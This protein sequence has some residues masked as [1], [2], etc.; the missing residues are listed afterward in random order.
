MNQ[1]LKWGI[2]NSDGT[3]D[4]STVSSDANAAPPSG[5]GLNAEA[6][7]ALLGGPSD[8]DLMKES[9]AA[10]RSPDI[11]L[12]N[13]LVAFDNLEQLVETIDNANNMEPLGLW[14]PLID[15][16]DS[17]EPDLRRMAA[18]C[19]GTAVQNNIKAQERVS[20]SLIPLISKKS[21]NRLQLLALNAIPT[22][23]KLAI[24]DVDE[25]VRRKAI[26]ALSSG[27]RNYQPATDAALKA[28][29]E[30]IFTG[31]SV[32]AGD[33]EAINGIMEKLRER[34]KQQ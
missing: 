20:Y 6:L 4:E 19:V 24:E 26:Y 25:N 12:E 27:I 7:T 5:H 29:P 14:T 21:A 28:L 2:Q 18:W 33:M 1:L 8:A 10:I 9:M 32:G 15:Q 22:L 16:L 17:G 34:S 23:V 30:E 13:K 11:N 31:G 3:L